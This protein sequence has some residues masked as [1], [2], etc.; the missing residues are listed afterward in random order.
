MGNLGER[1]GKEERRESV[2]GKEKGRGKVK[3]EEG[4][5][6]ERRK[7]EEEKEKKARI[8]KKYQFSW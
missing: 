6:K 2:G 4:K 1:K 7:C 5:W 3:F 8:E